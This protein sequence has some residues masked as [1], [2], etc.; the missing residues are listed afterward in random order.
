[1]TQSDAS[2][3]SEEKFTRQAVL[4]GQNIGANSL[5]FFVLGIYLI[6]QFGTWHGYAIMLLAGQAVVGGFVGASMA[7]RG[8]SDTAGWVILITDLIAPAFASLAITYLGYVAIAY[9]LLSAYFII[10]FA[11]KKV[12]RRTATLITLGLLVLPILAESINPAWRLSSQLVLTL[13]PIFTAVLGIVFVVV[14]LRQSWD[15]ILDF[16]R[17]SI[18]NRL[19]AIVVG[20]AVVPVLVISIFL[21][22]ITY[23]RV[24]EA[25]LQDTFD[26]LDAIESIK[27]TQLT[28]YMAERQNDMVTLRETAGA[29][30]QEAIAKLQAVNELKA[31][32]LLSS[33][34]VW[35]AD[36]RDVASDPGVVTGMADLALGFQGQGADY[37]RRFYLGKPEVGD[38]G[39]GTAYST[40]HFEQHGFFAG[41]TD[42]HG[43]ED[44]FLIDPAGNVVYSVHKTDIFGTN[45]VSGPYSDSNLA[46]LYQQLKDTPAGQA[47]VVDAAVLFDAYTMFIGTPVYAGDVLEGMLVYQLPLARIDAI[48]QD[49]VGLSASAETYLVGRVGEEIELR[50]NRVVK[51]GAIGDPKPGIDTERA[52]A[53]ESGSDFRVG[54]TGVYE[55]A[56]FSPLDLQGLNWAI[57]T[58]ASV[59][60][61]FVPQ[62]P[63]RAGDFLTE[64]KESYGFNDLFLISPDGFIFYSVDK[65]ADFQTNILT[66]EFSESNLAVLV[67]EI[68]AEKEYTFVDFDFYEPSGGTPAA[69]F[70][71][72]LLNAEG[73]IEMIV[74]AQVFV[75]D[76]NEIMN[77]ASGLGETGESYIIGQDFLGRMDSRFI[78][79]FGV[80]TTVMNPDYKVDTEAVRSALGGQSGQGTI[81][82]YR[83][84]PVLSVWKPFVVHE[85]HPEH[86]EGQVW[87]VMTEIDETEALEVANQ[88]AGAL[89]LII[90]LAAVAI[91]ALAVFVG[92]RFAT[93]FVNPILNLTDTATKVAGGDLSLRS[94]VDSVDELGTLSNTFNS[95][96]AQLQDTLEGLEQRVADRTK[97][98]ATSA[99]VT[100]RLAAILDPRQLALEVVEQVQR[101]FNYYYAQI[102]LLDES[103]ENLVL[104]GGTGEAG[105]AMLAR[106]HSVQKGRGL[107]GRAADTNTSVLVG[108]TLNEE[109]WL[110]NELLPETKAEAAV[111][112]SI[113][114]QVFGVLDVQH[115]F[116]GGLTPE[117]VTL[118]ESLAGQVAISLQNARSYEQSRKQ[119]ELESLVNVIGQRIQRATSI[120]DTLQ[121][122]IREL[123][124]AIGATR[125]RA[126]IKPASSAA[127]T[128]PVQQAEASVVT[129]SGNG[130]APDTESTPAG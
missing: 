99:E 32:A 112:I 51:Q 10:N 44:A 125:V 102:Y 109:G 42:I 108:D 95:M 22:W 68:L 3:P 106:G 36:V 113:G 129:A 12:V 67:S 46:A 30:R 77:E 13:A 41:Y 105:A 57:T 91:G 74:A 39:D 94:Q 9:I 47:T 26:R 37:I 89:G 64:F 79:Q 69:F 40:A 50:S 11:M 73:E 21:G 127:E 90:G 31:H 83:G 121:T 119:A 101:A 63:G 76:I 128:A 114:N 80:E 78:E 16:M 62:L 123:G 72:P 96:T 84:L 61:V 115:S 14:V 15:S 19:T 1:M 45:L 92:V 85:P 120:E 35:D 65:K 122:A 98:L 38:A 55:I 52:L 58:S 17:K 5:L 29:L 49:R 6:V 104:S 56:V 100:R 93:G 70:G 28:S 53:G 110:P 88:L 86:P 4:V 2:S 116:V 18:R 103:G 107:V 48:I 97:A 117:D 118:L 66:G 126:S 8:R 75:G 81:I 24:R 59:A 130:G 82:D 7:K 111:P 20:A 71:V 23:V 54:S 34:Q 25:L 27:T 87:A 43:Y 124:T 60:E 33:F